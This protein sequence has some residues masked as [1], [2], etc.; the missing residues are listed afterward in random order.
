MPLSCAAELL[1]DS[2]N[3]TL[4]NGRLLVSSTR[5]PTAGE[6]T[7]PALVLTGCC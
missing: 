6:I 5:T 7:A 2:V 4:V 3:V 1:S